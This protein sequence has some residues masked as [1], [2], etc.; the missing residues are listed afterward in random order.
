[1]AAGCALVGHF[2]AWR[3]H[4]MCRVGTG[5]KLTVK[6]DMH[7]SNWHLLLV[8]LAG[9]IVGTHQQVQVLAM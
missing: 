1:M 7:A 8:W 5:V 9:D 4:L 3:R 6:V 2:Q